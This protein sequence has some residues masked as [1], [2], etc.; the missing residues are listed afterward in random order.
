[1]EAEGEEREEEP[2]SHAAHGQVDNKGS[3][4]GGWRRIPG[5]Q[6]TNPSFVYTQPLPLGGTVRQ[7]PTLG[8]PV[9]QTFDKDP[10]TEATQLHMCRTRSHGG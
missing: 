1:M 5:V 4:T 2:G 6:A 9:R 8:G 10:N 3:N 7:T